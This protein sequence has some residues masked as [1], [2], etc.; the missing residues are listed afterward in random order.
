MSQ[1]DGLA[2]P[3]PPV[4]GHAEGQKVYTDMDMWTDIRR[5]VL[6]DGESKRAVQRR[7]GIH[8]STLQKILDHPE[9]PGYRLTQPRRK[10]VIADFLPLIHEIL[11]KDRKVH[12]KQ[13]HTS[14]R[15]FHRLRD[16]YGYQGGET[17]VKEA[18]RAWRGLRREAFVPLAH[19]L[20][21]AQVDFGYADVT[22]SG[23]TRKVAL[24]V[25]SLPYSDAFYMQ[26]YP[27]ECTEVFLD[28]HV[29]A[30][31]F[32]GGVPCRISYDNL[33]IAV[34]QITGGRG[35]QCTREFQRFLSHYLF[36]E[37]FCRVGRPNEKG[38]VENLVGYGRRNFL[39]PVPVIDDLK[40]LNETLRQRCKEDLDRT[41]RGQKH[42]KTVLLEEERPSFLPLPR[43]RF[44]ARRVVKTQASSL[45][46]VRFDNNDYSVPTACAFHPITAVAD[47]HEVRLV[48]EDELVACHE[49]SWKKEQVSFD[50]VHYLALLERKPGALDH[51]RPLEDWDLPE[52]FALLRRR[53]EAEFEGRGTLDYI[54][55]LRLLEK[56]S[57][58]DLKAAVLKSLEIGV[59]DAAAIRL[60]LEGLQEQPAALFSLDGRPHLSQVRVEAPDVT[61]YGA[62]TRSCAG[63]GA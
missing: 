27:R 2:S 31:E 15:I 29:R 48:C 1:L 45:S 7:Y 53:L 36:E 9:P 13:R 8:W 21:H 37:H 62:L 17:A 24:F 32:F 57:L 40:K 61:T 3:A 56:H 51:A 46:L 10:R 35:R 20:G 30:F 50:P 19:P 28:G 63:G 47:V 14:R 16:E 58:G 18:V 11:E 59:L 23:E 39:V 5:R 34:A 25:M 22:W 42:S 26:A 33:K 52:C 55:V 4:W 41:L 54:K 44:E 43:Q 60:I 6:V 38:H 12:R 49:R